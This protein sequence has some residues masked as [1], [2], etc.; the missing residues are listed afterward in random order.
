METMN[1]LAAYPCCLVT[2]LAAA[3]QVAIAAGAPR[4]DY[5]LGGAFP[6]QFPPALTQR[7]P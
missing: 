4:G 7:P 5:A 6:H 2:V 3:F 1:R